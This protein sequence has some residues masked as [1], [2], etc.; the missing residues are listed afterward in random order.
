[1][2][3][4]LSTLF[5]FLGLLPSFVFAKDIDIPP[6]YVLFDKIVVVVNGT[7]VLKSEV[8]L[9]K[10]FYNIPDDKEA[11]KHLI[12]HILLSQAAE[13]M[14]IKVSAEEINRFLEELARQNNYNSVD[15]FL[16][17]LSRNNISVT[18]LKNLIRRQILVN[19]FVG[20]Y[21]RDRV[22]GNV[23][24]SDEAKD[25]EIATIQIIVLKKDNPDFSDKYLKLKSELKE[26]S[27]ANLF[28]KYNED[29]LLDMSKGIIKNVKKGM[30]VDVIDSQLWKYQKGDIFEVDTAE[31]VYFIKIIDK[32]RNVNENSLNKEELNKR[33][34]EEIDRIIEKLRAN[35]VITYLD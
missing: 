15:E 25:N 8:E 1:M 26:E 32:K 34:K 21:V 22:L 29:E 31:K 9:F 19:K 12:N 24:V 10:N 4:F 28:S 23:E 3:K 27:F 20:S 14:G 6:G 11:M 35:S 30:L 7:P 18:E 2:R 17:D 5:I 13:K 33:I 16:Y